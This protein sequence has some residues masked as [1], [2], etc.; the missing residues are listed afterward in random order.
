MVNANSTDS[1]R[2]AMAGRANGLHLP[3]G[4]GLSGSTVTSP[5]PVPSTVLWLTS[6]FVRVVSPQPASN[7]KNRN[8]LTIEF[9]W[10]VTSKSSRFSFMD[11]HFFFGGI[12]YKL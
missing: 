1:P 5:P 6:C 3:L 11:V 9:T 10:T 12:D 7:K 8:F 2:I 4:K